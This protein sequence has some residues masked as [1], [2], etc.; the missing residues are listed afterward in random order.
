MT[1]ELR[2]SPLIHDEGLI[3]VTGAPDQSPEGPQGRPVGRAKNPLR[4]DG[5]AYFI[6]FRVGTGGL[7]L[8]VDFCQERKYRK[9]TSSH[10]F[11][12]IAAEQRPY[13]RSP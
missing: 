10:S 12:A 6:P 4:N 5:P 13:G 3:P 9:V 8:A 1:Q 2:A 7:F 11:W